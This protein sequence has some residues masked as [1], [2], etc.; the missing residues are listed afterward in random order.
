MVELERRWFA[1]ALLER[2][3]AK[4]QPEDSETRERLAKITLRKQGI[5]N[6]IE[7]LERLRG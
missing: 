2:E 5:M 1:A 7:A 6:E 4:E 3:L